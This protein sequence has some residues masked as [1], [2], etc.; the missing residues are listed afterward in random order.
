[1]LLVHGVLHVVVLFAVDLKEFVIFG[2]ISE[3]SGFLQLL[4]Q[5]F[6][7]DLVG[8]LP[9]RE[10]LSGVVALIQVL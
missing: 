10:G 9:L 5:H 7:R 1:M 8:F 4:G 2:I 6:L 3:G